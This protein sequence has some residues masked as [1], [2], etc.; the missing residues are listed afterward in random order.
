MSWRQQIGKLREI[1]R[2]RARDSE[3]AEEIQT[4]LELEELDNR[5]FGMLPDEAHYAAVRRLGNATLVL[6]R[7]REM[8][9][10]A[11]LETMGQDLR[12]ALRQLRRSPGFTAVAVL[13]LALGIGANTAIFQLLDAVRLRS[14]PVPSPHE[15]A[16]IRI[17]GGNGGLGIVTSKYAQLTR[18]ILQELQRQQQPF[19]SVFAWSNGGDWV[20]KDAGRKWAIELF[21]S[22]NLFR[23]LG[24]TPARGRLLR[25]EDEGPCPD[26]KVVVSYAFWQGQMGGRDLSA[27][28]SLIVD[29][30]LKQVVG[31]TPPGFF[32]PAIGD[33]FDIARPFCQAAE[34]L[35][36]DLFDIAVMGRL[37]PGWSLARASAQL[38]AI[39]P[40]IFEATVP[41]GRSSQS[42]TAYKRFKLAA[43]PAANGVSSLRNDYDSSL[44]L[45]VGITALVLLI[46]CANLANLMLAR[47][48]TREREIAVRLALGAS[49]ARLLRQLLVES[50]LLATV[51]AVIGI[52]VAE[53][54]SR[55]L[56]RSLSTDTSAVTLSVST[57]WRVL[58]FAALAAALT[59]A[60]FGAAPA[61]RA[62]RVDPV[63]SMKGASRGMTGSRE[64]FSMQ[65][66]MVITQIAVSLLLLVG[67]LLF[68]RSFRNL[69]TFDP[70]MRESGITVAIVAFQHSH[71]A[72]DQLIEFKRQLLEDVSSAPGILSAATTTNMP[73]L[74]G[75]WGHEVHVG[76]TLSSSKFTWV[77]PDYF[78][79]MGIPVIEGRG[80]SVNDN[81]TSQ[82]VAIVNRAFV[83]HLLGGADPLGKTMRTD[84]EPDYPST[85]YQIVGVIPDTQYDGLRGQTPPMTFAPAPQCP[86]QGPWVVMMIHSNLPYGTV[87]STVK[88][89]IAAK[90]PEIVTMT[91]DFQTSIRDG[92]VRER[93]MA[94]L[95]GL[96]GLLA[97]VLA[98]VG[99]YGVIS[100][101]VSRRRN[102]IGI[103]LALG[104]R[105]GQVIGMVLREAVR[106]LVIGA[107]IG[108]VLSLVAGRTAGSLLFRLKPYDPLTLG[109]A[110]LLL[111]LIALLASFLP[112]RR[113]SKVDPMEALRCE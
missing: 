14:L 107:L 16:E 58:L 33:T 59:C 82:R 71:V 50:A 88:G 95:S 4:H 112:A 72:Q 92:L 81:Q 76:S 15:L 84:P 113:A 101:I 96:F 85:V 105:R 49:R 100:F 46:A 104:A 68:V 25:P 83:R 80:F 90:H 78:R 28:S 110:V 91:G 53:A 93:M 109:V 13:T 1:F 6:E 42:T 86:A 60:V 17:A 56:V 21:V 61:M 29:G 66:L 31:V 98:M 41:P 54:V 75:S 64:R 27:D 40:G 34:P 69:M 32:G 22:G 103:R 65:R 11:W 77:S 10:W 57:D 63:S 89:A 55:I 19:S 67:A 87:M 7:S 5:E 18:P 52:G 94:T 43:Y 99:L 51:G 30:E 62:T 106:L 3:L 45:L 12:Y 70:G 48:S 102:E 39:S 8:W 38:Q 108:A 44:W 24:V 97:A 26:S 2:G 111:A 36:R 37:K 20:G 74:G 47:A 79:T 35:R 23:V 9:G 73:L